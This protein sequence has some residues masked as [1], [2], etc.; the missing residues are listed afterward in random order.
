MRFGPDQPAAIRKMERVLTD[1]ERA[2]ISVW[3]GLEKFPFFELLDVTVATHLGAA[4]VRVAF[5]WDANRLH[6]LF[7]QVGFRQVTS[8]RSSSQHASHRLIA[9]LSYS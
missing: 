7:T 8:K 2:V 4:A 6:A 1:G 5:S 9:M 3:H